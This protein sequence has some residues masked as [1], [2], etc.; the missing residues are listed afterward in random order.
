VNGMPFRFKGLLR[1]TDGRRQAGVQFIDMIPRRCDELRE[2]IE[3][4]ESAAQKKSAAK[5]APEST[6]QQPEPQPEPEPA[7]PAA[8]P[9]VVQGKRAERRA[10][11]RQQ[12]DTSAN[13]I[14]VRGGSVLSGRIVDLSL[15]G[16]RIHTSELF[17]VDIYTRVEIEFQLRGMPFRLGGV[18]QALHNRD[19]VGI[20]FLDV[21]ARKRQQVAELIEEIEQARKATDGNP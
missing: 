4:L 18:V 8:V 16:C 20:R 6:Q 9:A 3:E 15:G 19:T 12:V 5:L 17:S 2:L 10:Q 13:L 21:S 11:A 1:W 14:L 7:P